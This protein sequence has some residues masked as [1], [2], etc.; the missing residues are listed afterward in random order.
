MGEIVEVSK[1]G[2]RIHKGFIPPIVVKLAHG[3]KV[4]YYEDTI[5][6]LEE[7]L[8]LAQNSEEELKALR[9]FRELISPTCPKTLKTVSLFQ[10]SGSIRR[11]DC[12]GDCKERTKIL[13]QLTPRPRV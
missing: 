12:R 7:D 1:K 13:A 10:C 2:L 6:Q 8:K 11:G 3:P 5:K 9:S 4:A